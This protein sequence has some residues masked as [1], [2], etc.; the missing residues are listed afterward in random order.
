MNLLSVKCTRLTA[1]KNTLYIALVRRN[2]LWAVK[3]QVFLLLYHWGKD[4]LSSVK[5]Q[6]YHSSTG[7]D[8][9]SLIILC[10]LTSMERNPGDC[11]RKARE[12]T[13]CS[14]IHQHKSSVDWDRD[15][16]LEADCTTVMLQ[17]EVVSAG[18][19]IAHSPCPCNKW[20][21]LCSYQLRL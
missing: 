3:I 21:S 4:W 9:W 17:P 1:I 8:P 20:P 2:F 14:T 11:G 15:G 16:W 7:R 6:P 13:V 12:G 5:V 18:N 10:N 19:T